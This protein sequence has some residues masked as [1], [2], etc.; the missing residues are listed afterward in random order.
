MWVWREARY[1]AAAMDVFSKL[2]QVLVNLTFL[3]V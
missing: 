3:I 2:A 1:N